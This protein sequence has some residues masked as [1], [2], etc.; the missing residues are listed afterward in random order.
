MP[1]EH[2]RA[3]GADVYIGD[4]RLP[5]V[6]QDV[7]VTRAKALYSVINDDYAN[8]EIGLNA[9]SF[10][11]DLRLILRIFDDSMSTRIK[12]HLDIHLTFSMSAIADGQFLEEVQIS[13]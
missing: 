12:E 8:L 9:R 7:N 10:Q 13:R 11:P 5:R 6:L 3:R 2:L 1:S 4:A